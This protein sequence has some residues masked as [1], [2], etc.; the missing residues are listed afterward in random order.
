[1]N[2]AYCPAARGTYNT[3]TL[4]WTSTTL[5]IDVNGRT[6]LV[7]TSGNQAFKKRYIAAFTQGI[8][9]GA[10]RLRWNTP[11]P[12]TLNVDYLRVWR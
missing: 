5:K 9:V 11:M 3:Y 6:C 12:A 1:V 4:T 2:T 7:N 10:N 8:G